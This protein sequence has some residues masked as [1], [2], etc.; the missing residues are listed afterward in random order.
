[1]K[2]RHFW[3]RRR[4]W[5]YWFYWSYWYYQFRWLYWPR[6]SFT[7][8]N[9]GDWKYQNGEFYISRNEGMYPNF[10]LRCVE[11]PKSTAVSSKGQ[12]LFFVYVAIAPGIRFYCEFT[13]NPWWLQLYKWRMRLKRYASKSRST[14]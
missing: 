7:G 14:R 1:M 11:Y 8:Y 3:L 6:W 9:F 2:T 5:P 12:K 13:I 10:C 4:Y